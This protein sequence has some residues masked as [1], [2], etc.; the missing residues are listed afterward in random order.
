MKPAL[1]SLTSVSEIRTNYLTKIT[2]VQITFVVLNSG[3]MGF[4]LGPEAEA[5]DVAVI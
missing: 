2:I 3:V 5:E 4:A 1:G